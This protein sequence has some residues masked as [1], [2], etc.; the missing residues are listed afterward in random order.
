MLSRSVASSRCL[1]FHMF[2]C[3]ALLSDDASVALSNPP[4]LLA[5]RSFRSGFLTLRSEILRLALRVCPWFGFLS[6]RS[7]LIL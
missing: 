4:P 5:R 6:L 1:R 2:C 7:C 3:S